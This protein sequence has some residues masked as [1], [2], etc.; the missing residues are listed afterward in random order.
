[1][2]MKTSGNPAP[3]LQAHGGNLSAQQNSASSLV[4]WRADTFMGAR[5]LL[6]SGYYD[7][8]RRLDCDCR[9][10]LTNG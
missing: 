4:V 8:D 5:N 3:P 1:M 6:D 10:A 2:L 7:R 9:D